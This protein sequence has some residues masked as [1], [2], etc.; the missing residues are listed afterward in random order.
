MYPIV[1]R[2]SPSG[3]QHRPNNASPDNAIRMKDMAYYMCDNRHKFMNWY[4]L[5]LDASKLLLICE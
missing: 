3:L 2:A 1:A 5:L 4:L